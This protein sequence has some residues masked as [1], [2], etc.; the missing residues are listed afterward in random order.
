MPI[1]R[2]LRNAGTPFLVLFVCAPLLHAQRQLTSDDI[3]FRKEV[4]VGKGNKARLPYRLF[5]PTGY[6]ANRKYPLILWLHGGTGRGVDNLKQLEN[7]NQLATH[8]WIS[9]AVQSKFPV[10]VMAPQ[11]PP[12]QL[13]AEPE[14]NIPSESLKLTVAALAKVQKDFSIDPDRIYVGGQS[15]GGSGVWSLLQNYPEIWAAAIIMSAYDNFTEP[16]AVA[17]IPLWVFQGDADASVPVGTVRTMM[18]Q[19][20]KLHANL[21]YTEYRKT[22]HEVWNKAFA[23]P[24]LVDWLSSQ[25]RPSAQP[26]AASQLGSPTPLDSR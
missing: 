4:F 19:L 2:A 1:L 18:A 20:R 16:D 13:W 26:P 11:C 23:E 7:Q 3:N 12:G 22:D 24:D 25:K 17:R 8:F 10:F 5:V 6:D 9:D 21:R 14:F 15:M